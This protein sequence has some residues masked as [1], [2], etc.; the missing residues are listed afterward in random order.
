MGAMRLLGAVLL[1]GLLVCG[2]VARAAEDPV[3][4]FGMSAAFTGPSRGLGIELYRGASACFEQVNAKG[5]VHGR[6]LGITALDDG[7]NPLP[8]IANTIQFIERDDVF[9][10][11][12]Y[13]GTPT[14]TRILPLLLKYRDRHV[15]LLFPFTGAEPHRSEPYSEFVFNLRASYMQETEAVVDRLIAL[16]RTRVG[17]FYQA[18]AYGRGGWDG[19]RR[20]LAKYGLKPVADVSYPRGSGTEYSY[21]EQARLLHEADIDAVVCIGTYASGAGFIRDLRDMGNTA[22]AASVSFA[23]GDN[24]IRLLVEMGG[25]AGVDYTADLVHM[26]VVPCYE[27]LGLPAVRAY[28]AAMDSYSGVLP[29]HLGKESYLPKRYSAVSFEGYMNA[30]LIV[31]MLRR[32]GANPDKSKIPRVLESMADLDVGLDMPVSFGPDRHQGLDRVYFMMLSG[33]RHVPVADWERWRR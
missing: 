9:A 22:L 30:R 32:M 17:I 18:D 14:V 1:A 31:E 2:G 4:T 28:R 10:L 25:A 19:V 20:A 15:Y 11:F 12:S 23:D 8:T 5:G 24:L 33:G 7:Y 26:Q 27:D 21:T 13:V 3:I 29:A 16:G 6:K